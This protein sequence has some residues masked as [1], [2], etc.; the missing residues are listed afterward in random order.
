MYKKG[1][2][3]PTSVTCLS[4]LIS[5]IAGNAQQRRARRFRAG[6]PA[7]LPGSRLQSCAPWGL[8]PSN[9]ILGTK[10]YFFVPKR[11]TILNPKLYFFV[12]KNTIFGPKCYFFVKKGTILDPKWY[13]LGQ[14]KYHFGPK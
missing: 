10:C 12:Q 9:T 13:L 7:V 5:R 14:K 1:A 6:R 4:F 3:H 11:G 2:H 8:G